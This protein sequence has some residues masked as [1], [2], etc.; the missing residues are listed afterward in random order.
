M[1]QKIKI[2]SHRGNVNGPNIQTENTIESITLAINM[3]FDVEIDVWRLD[4]DL[5]LGHDLNAL[6][7]Y[8]NIDSFLLQHAS[9]LWI[10]C[11]N[12]F[13]LEY[14]LKFN[15]LNIFIHSDDPYTLT[16]HNDILCKPGYMTN[17]VGI[18]MMPEVTSTY[19]EK[20]LFDCVG[21]MTDYPIDIKDK[22]LS[23]FTE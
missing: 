12:L 19:T 22:N 18:I 23:R 16:S 14:L 5:H 4:V 10:H 15:S 11:K 20:T 2:I 21:V 9:K 1:E 3:G 17:G 8:G 6:K 7:T 13:A